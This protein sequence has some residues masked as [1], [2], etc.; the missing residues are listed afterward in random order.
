MIRIDEDN[1]K[2]IVKKSKAAKLE[3]SD[4]EDNKKQSSS[5]EGKKNIYK[6][7]SKVLSSSDEGK[8][9]LTKKIGKISSD[10]EKNIQKKL[11]LAKFK[12]EEESDIASD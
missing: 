10:E 7:N 11:N 1:K 4:D 12:N 6:K 5:D 8:K 9:N 3:L 2:N